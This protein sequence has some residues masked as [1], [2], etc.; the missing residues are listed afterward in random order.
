MRFLPQR[1]RYLVLR[2]VQ[3]PVI[4]MSLRHAILVVAL[5]AL[6][7]FFPLVVSVD[8]QASGGRG[9]A[10]TAAQLLY[11]HGRFWWIVGLALVVVALDAVRI[12]HR[13]SGPLYRMT[14]AIEEASSGRIPDPIR[15]REGDHLHR[16]AE[17]LNAL[18]RYAAGLRSELEQSLTRLDDEMRG[19][20]DGADPAGRDAIEERRQSLAAILARVESHA[21]DDAAPQPAREPARARP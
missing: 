6:A 9:A 10:D 19:L 17:A 1:R 5:L 21:G 14:R 2:H 7:L 15:L 16:E 3:I 11:L 18:F 20:C 8:D 12:S 13:F 4:A